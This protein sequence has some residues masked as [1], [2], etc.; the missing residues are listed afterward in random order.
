MEE[1]EKIYE[2]QRKSY[3]I[4]MPC[5]TVTTL[6]LIRVLLLSHYT[7][8][9]HSKSILLLHYFYLLTLIFVPL[10]GQLKQRNIKDGNYIERL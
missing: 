9:E 1:K 4:L 7:S 2:R 10:A 8:E 3:Q 5:Q 6:P